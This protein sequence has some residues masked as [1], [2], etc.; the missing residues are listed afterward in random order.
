M[1]SITDWNNSQENF[2]DSFSQLYGSYNLTQE[3][4]AS[5]ESAER[6]IEFMH[7]NP[8]D[9][10]LE[11]GCGR[12]EWLLRL[13]KLGYQV[14]GVDISQKSLDLLNRFSG[15][16]QLFEKIHLYKGDAQEDL[17]GVL[18]NQ[19]FDL[20]FGYNLLH[21]VYDIEKTI[22]NMIS[23][24]KPEGRVV[25]YEPNPFHFWWYVCPLFDKKFKWSIEKGLL[26]TS[27]IKMINMFK[28]KGLGTVT[29]FSADYFPFI[30][31]DKTFRLTVLFNKLLCNLP[32]LRYLP[33]VYYL[34][35]EKR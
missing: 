8:G 2:F 13:V 11:L 29:L 12:G 22:D 28:S 24:T 4:S 5:K 7:L 17:T 9:T 31:P 32:V 10:I 25:V 27:P 23:L 20:V 16:S 21:H 18:G 33:A 6:F 15:K 3:S 30:S 1:Q 34:R 19:Q 35:G 14:T 26:K